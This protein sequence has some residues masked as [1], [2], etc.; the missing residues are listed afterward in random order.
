MTIRI[1]FL[2]IDQNVGKFCLCVV[3]IRPFTV[4]DTGGEMG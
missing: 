4:I 2:K 1:K 3:G